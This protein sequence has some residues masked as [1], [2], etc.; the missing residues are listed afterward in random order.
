M[1]DKTQLKKRLRHKVHQLEQRIKRKSQINATYS[2]PLFFPV[3]NQSR[4]F[5]RLHRE[6]IGYEIDRSKPLQGNA[7]ILSVGRKP[8]PL[9]QG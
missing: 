8:S 2:S 3:P 5:I 4:S 6:N 9:F 7:L 1:N